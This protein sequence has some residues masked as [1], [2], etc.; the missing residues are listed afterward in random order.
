[1]KRSEARSRSFP[2]PRLPQILALLAGSILC[3][4]PLLRAQQE[5]ASPP[6]AAEL[7]IAIPQELVAPEPNAPV[8]V[9]AA[10]DHYDPDGYP[11]DAEGLL[12]VRKEDPGY[13]VY[14]KGTPAPFLLYAQFANMQRD[15][16]FLARTGSI[17]DPLPDGSSRLIPYGC[18]ALKTNASY[19]SVVE[20]LLLPHVSDNRKE[21]Q[22]FPL[23]DLYGVA[24]LGLTGITAGLQYVWAEK[25]LGYAYAGINL[26]GG[27]GWEALGP[28][29]WYSVP[30]H[31]G[32][33][34]RF[35]NLL[36]ALL[37][38]NHWAVGAELFLGLGDADRDPATPAP[39]WAPGVFFEVETSEPFGWGKRWNGL[40]EHGD[41]REDPRPLNYYVRALF[42]RVALYAD[43]QSGP[44]TGPL[45]VNVS[46][47]FRYNLLGPSIPAHRF[48]QTRVLYLSEEYRQQLELQ[49]QRR[50][51]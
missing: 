25:L 17:E 45:K 9:D 33:G 6:V 51:Q 32:A 35:A 42:L 3:L 22:I 18:G 30:L 41:Y 36:P 7:Q 46:T 27:S 4:P 19:I 16:V 31:L 34:W 40:S 14:M 26:L 39:L 15:A 24:S 29:G 20:G 10:V 21:Y 37:R 13:M 44:D 28:L 2:R 49:R 50:L 38:P 5:A 43:L 12:A 23:Q 48:K 47:G 1:M 8:R 11:E